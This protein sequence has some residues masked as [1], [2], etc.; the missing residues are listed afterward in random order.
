[1]IRGRDVGL[2]WRALVPLLLPVLADGVLY[3]IDG[4]DPRP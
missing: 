1:M 3:V 2:V 4:P